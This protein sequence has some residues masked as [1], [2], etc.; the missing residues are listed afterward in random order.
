[1][2]LENQYIQAKLL[3]QAAD[4]LYKVAYLLPPTGDVPRNQAYTIKLP[5][6]TVIMNAKLMLEIFQATP[7]SHRTLYM[8]QLQPS[9]HYLVTAWEQLSPYTTLDALQRKS[10]DINALR[11][12][13]LLLHSIYPTTGVPGE[14]V[15][16]PGF[17][18]GASSDPMV[19]A[20]A[21]S[22][23]AHFSAI[24]KDKAS[25]LY[26]ISAKYDL[27]IAENLNRAD[28]LATWDQ[29]NPALFQYEP[30]LSYMPLLSRIFGQISLEI[31]TS[32]LITRSART[33][34]RKQ[35]QFTTYPGAR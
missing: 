18:L 24:A 5:V 21:A 29:A 2:N 31:I 7:I 22:L 6:P 34:K 8:D 16:V 13:T 27:Q 25:K 15:A 32:L 35:L 12:V 4:R 33:M 1:M 3:A 23:S 17:S 30:Q 14:R 28:P 26:A 11:Q 19:V 20:K 10:K 9:L